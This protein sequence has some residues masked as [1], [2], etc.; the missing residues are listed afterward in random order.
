MGDASS[1]QPARQ[2]TE[3][4]KSS[5]SSGA[6]DPCGCL[7]VLAS[8]QQ[9]VC[10]ANEQAPARKDLPRPG[11]ETPESE[12]AQ[13]PEAPRRALKLVLTLQPHEGPSYRAIVALGADG[14]DPLLRY[15][16]VPDLA[17]ALEEVPGLLAEAEAV[18]QIQP[19]YP[20]IVPPLKARSTTTTSPSTAP[21]ELAPDETEA[22]GAGPAASQPSVKSARAGQLS[23]FE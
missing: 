18:W 19:R 4:A 5:L 17:T 21:H 13:A 11:A 14:C 3:P 9:A 2:E 10:G 23:F 20:A 22:H 12:L 7:A 6:L 16:E 1:Q 15:V 8:E